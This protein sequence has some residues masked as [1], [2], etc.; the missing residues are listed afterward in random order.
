MNWGLRIALL[1]MGFVAL[2]LTLVFTCYGNQT[3]LESKDYYARE[4]KFQDQIDATNNSLSLKSSLQCRVSGKL[5][6]LI[7]PSELNPAG[8][9][10]SVSFLRPSNASLDR[11]YP[12]KTDSHGRQLISDAAFSAGLYKLKI[13]Y[14]VAGKSYYHEEA[15]FF[16]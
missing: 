9:K 12:I 2:I 11:Q 15:V 7:F 14:T 16:N 6:E 13:D 8:I 4:L 1:Y 10:G 5:V 3:E